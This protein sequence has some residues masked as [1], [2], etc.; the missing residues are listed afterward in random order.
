[1]TGHKP[2]DL[3]AS[4]R[5]LLRLYPRAYRRRREE[6]MLGMLLESSTPGQS[7]PAARDARSL[8]AGAARAWL[9][10]FF[11][12]DPAAAR[13]AFALAAIALPMLHLTVAAAMLSR[14]FIAYAGHEP[15]WHTV[16]G[17]AHFYWSWPAWC[18]LAIAVG[19][20]VTG[21]SRPARMASIAAAVLF[22]VLGPR[23]FN[24]FNHD[25]ALREMSWAISSCIQAALLSRDRVAR[26]RAFLNRWTAVG[27]CGAAV[28]LGMART[29]WQFR[30]PF[31]SVTV[32][33]DNPEAYAVV[34][35]V[36]VA[37]LATRIGRVLAPFAGAGFVLLAGSREW[38]FDYALEQLPAL[39]TPA[40]VVFLVLRLLASIAG[41]AAVRLR[42]ATGR[43]RRAGS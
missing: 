10:W 21:S 8:L 30:D 33:Y 22:V 28:A 25:T 20:V 34:M 2:T 18:L 27:A 41:A 17:F 15:W 23:N 43:S 29:S 4:Y 32:L 9:R 14:L 35:L 16:R 3:E 7:R 37:A 12:P 24:N 39:V 19:A 42:V 40:L 26:G 13:N 38:G 5:R 11:V 1:M 6:E 31:G 36:T